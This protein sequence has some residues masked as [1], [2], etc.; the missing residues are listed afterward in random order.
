MDVFLYYLKESTV[1]KLYLYLKVSW[2]NSRT[3]QIIKCPV[4]RDSLALRLAIRPYKLLVIV[5]R[6]FLFRGLPG[7]FK[8]LLMK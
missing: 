1:Y 8:I 7:I 3:R 6:F 2:Q 5:L 4:L